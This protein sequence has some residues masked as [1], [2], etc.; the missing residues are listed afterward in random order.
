MKKGFTLIEALVYIA[1]FAIIMTGLASAAWLLFET[2]D[3]N[4][5]KAMLQEERDFLLGK[6]GWAL[7]N[8]SSATSGGSSLTVTKY[9]G[10]TVRVCLSG[11]DMKYL[12]GLS[13]TCV[14]SGAVLNNSNV[15]ITNLA[16]SVSGDPVEIETVLTISA[17]TPNG[18]AISQV[19]TSTRYIRK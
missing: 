2:S 18:L 5:T 10:S 13:G 11:T 14:A 6:V 17:K 15:S 7:N 8:A 9:D 4:Q 1:L 19:A 3:R 16:F 12:E